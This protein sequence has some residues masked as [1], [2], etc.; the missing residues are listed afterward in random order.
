[1]VMNN[2]MFYDMLISPYIIRMVLELIIKEWP[3]LNDVPLDDIEDRLWCQLYAE[4][5]NRQRVD[6][7]FHDIA[8]KRLSVEWDSEL[9]KMKA[10]VQSI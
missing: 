9:E 10:A 3:R 5:L 6:S 4:L 8:F 1:M 2:K 7:L